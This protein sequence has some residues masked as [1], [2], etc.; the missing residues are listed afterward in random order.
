MIVNNK[1]SQKSNW[2]ISAF[3][4]IRAY[5]ALSLALICIITLIPTQTEAK[6]SK[7]NVYQE[8]YAAFVMDAD[9]GLILHRENAN[10]TLHPASL[11]K[12]MTLLMVFD[13]IDSGKLKLYHRVRI[14]EHA[15]SMIP[16]KLDL[17]V[18]SSIKVKDAIYAL[19]TKSANDVAVAIAEKLGGTEAN[20]AKMMTKKARKIGMTK[21]RFKN[22]SG[23]HDPRQVS[24]ARDI[25]RLSRTLINDYRRHYHYFS[26]QSFT[27][28][29]KTYKSHNKLMQTYQGMDGLKTGYIKASGFNL[30]AS[31]VQNDRRLIGVVFGGRTGKLRNAQMKKLLDDAFQ[32]VQT[33]QIANRNVP[34]PQTKPEF[35]T[36]ELA[37]V[38]PATKSY[39]EPETIDIRPPNVSRWDMLDSSLEHS[40]FN[41]MIGQGDYDQTVRSRIETGLIAISAHMKETLPPELYDDEERKP[42][43]LASN[44]HI[45]NDLSQTGDWA[46]QIGAFTTRDRVD[47]AITQSLNK[48]PGDLK[49]GS[50]TVA[51]LKTAQGWIYRGR[52]QGYTKAAAND[53]CKILHD[54]IPIAP[55]AQ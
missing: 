25:A 9:T 36:L 31:A 13:A 12:M 45:K 2:C 8:K 30:A 11:T 24:T 23:L 44:G 27:Y 35:Q 15:A 32:K 17:P 1:H 55:D 48:L 53:A 20:F 43:K 28:Q 42:V 4:N 39:E 3:E 52:L 10:K 49:H 14:S 34:I 19:T 37:S 29:G 18:G 47:V 22:A 40:M 46:I 41:R 33:L 21:T 26:T 6:R 16:S 7:G 54:C 38:E 51:P 50:T 5:F